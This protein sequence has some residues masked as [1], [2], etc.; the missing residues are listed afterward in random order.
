MPVDPK[1]R[2]AAFWNENPCG[3]AS[4]WR[5][6]QELRFRYTD[7]YLLPLLEGPLLRDR[8]VLEI[9][10]GQGL[11]AERIVQVCRSYTGVDLSEASVEIAREVVEAQKPPHVET[12]LRVA[13]AERLDFKD[14]SFDAIYSVGVLHHT[15]DF[16]AAL[17]ELHRVLEPG[18][19]VVLMLYRGFTP[20]WWMLRGV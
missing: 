3:S 12:Q 16:E 15:P 2:G 1:S 6:A 13:D 4:S 19:T 5:T 7:P 11:D 8:R 10:C 9:G 17:S 18:G 20:L 14:A